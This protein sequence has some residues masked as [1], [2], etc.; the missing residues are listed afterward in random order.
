MITC[1]NCQS[2]NQPG[3]RFC[4]SCGLALPNAQLPENTRQ[5]PDNS[6]I[7][8]DSGRNTK[9]LTSA[10]SFTPLPDGAII[11]ERFLVRQQLESTPYIFSY[12][13]EDTT[14]PERPDYY[15]LRDAQ[16]YGRFGIEMDIANL[17]LKGPGLRPPFHLFQQ[18]IGGITRTFL[19][20]PQ[21]STPLRNLPLPLELPKV[22]NWGATLAK[23]L[24]ALHQHQIVF[25]QMTRQD[26]QVDGDNIFLAD[27]SHCLK[28]GTPSLY[29]ED[30]RYLALILH[31]CLA[32][33][34]QIHL[35]LTC[36]NHSNS[37]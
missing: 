9:P 3:K 18:A 6:A 11:A 17:P 32:A 34:T 7:P 36:Q 12:V 16:E 33:K 26:I 23:A 35:S 4:T 2:Q 30:V 8:P 10:P 21:P 19:V 25:G 37:Y 14:N 20:Y 29:Q 1:P 22:V 13:V 24:A 27:F 5:L 15:I 28:P 31:N